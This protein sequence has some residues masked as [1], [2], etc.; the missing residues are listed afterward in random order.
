MQKPIF[1]ASFRNR[2]MTRISERGKSIFASPFRKY[3]PYADAAKARGIDVIHL[4]IGQ[5]DFLMPDGI[6]DSFKWSASSFVPYGIAEGENELRATWA[7]YYQKFNI[8][9]TAENVMV[10]TGASEA[11]QM[12]LL[13]IADPGD[14]AIVPEPFYANYN[15]F[16][17][18]A[19]VNI[20]PL[21][22]SIDDGFPIPPSVDFE[23]A[24][25]ER[26]RCILI[27]NPNNPT[28]KIFPQEQLRQLVRL[29]VKHDLFLMVDEAYSEFVYQT[30]D[31]YSALTFADADQ[32]VIVIDSVSKR[33][34]ACGLRVG[35]LVSRN[36]ALLDSITNLSRLRL[37]PPMLAQRMAIQLLK[38]PG[39]Y[40][41][42]V[43]EEF[44]H[45]RALMLD[46]LKKI[47]GL[48]FH[49]PEGAFYIF[50]RLPIEDSEDFSR[51]LLTDFSHQGQTVMI[52]PGTGFYASPGQGLNEV[53][54]AYVL[55]EKRLS[56]AM[57]CLEQALATYPKTV[58]AAL[59][60]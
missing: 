47:D 11:L 9:V 25:T 59:K 40:Y 56:A 53:R 17:Q 54:I 10:T 3:L 29:A 51:W 34:N 58:S 39:S 14:E 43:L 8:E 6:L 15:G 30:Y 31:F 20:V 24:I 42:G 26:T 12:A 50:A 44:T 33:F 16:C 13:A 32:H 2:V 46:R 1:A 21:P 19:G 45:R 18:I 4:N 38:S 48:D 52:A 36:A 49:A 37:S 7:E 55:E 27:S 60:A 41:A 23:A 57:D 22:T 28:G 5:P 35:A